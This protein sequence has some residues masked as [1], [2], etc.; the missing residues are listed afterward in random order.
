[1]WSTVMSCHCLTSP[2]T[3]IALQFQLTHNLHLSGT[4]G[5]FSNH[6]HFQLQQEKLIE[7]LIQQSGHRKISLKFLEIYFSGRKPASL[8]VLV[9]GRVVDIS[10]L[11][12]AMSGPDDEYNAGDGL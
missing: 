7:L 12:L 8:A 3:D 4:V 9:C 6:K 2:D 11:S 10:L 5:R 1:M